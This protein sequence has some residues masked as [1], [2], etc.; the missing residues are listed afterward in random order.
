MRANVPTCI[1]IDSHWA[2]LNITEHCLICSGANFFFG[3]K[4]VAMFDIIKTEKFN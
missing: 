4:N 2:V 3:L 1:T